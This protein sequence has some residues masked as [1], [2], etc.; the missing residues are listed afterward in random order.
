[1][2]TS[3]SEPPIRIVIDTREQ[4]AYA[5]PNAVVRSL[6]SGDYS[7][8]G[9]EDRVAIE[10]KTKSD[11]FNSLGRNR[12]RFE[13]EVQRLAELR[14]AAIVIEASLA[15]FLRAPAFSQMSARAAARSLL[16]WSVRYRLP[17]FWAGDR[18]HGR[19]VTMRLLEAFVRYER[20]NRPPGSLVLPPLDLVGAPR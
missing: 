16:A 4:R 10:R 5:F 7:I 19:A 9:L 2:A 8:E 13:R 6:R 15:D 20:G 3:R 11:A 18:R 12:G 14:Y 17:V 1:M